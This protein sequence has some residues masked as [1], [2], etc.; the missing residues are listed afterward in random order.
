MRAAEPLDLARP[1]ADLSESLD[2]RAAAGIAK[3]KSVR[4]APSSYAAVTQTNTTAPGTRTHGKIFGTIT[5]VGGFVCSGTVV[6]SPNESTVWT[7]AHCIWDSDTDSFAT[8]LVFVPGYNNGARPFG[9][10]AARDAFVPGNWVSSDGTDSRD[11]VGTL[12]I[13]KKLR[14]KTRREKRKCN[15]RFEDRPAK[16]RRCKRKRVRG[17]VKDKVGARGIAFEQ[18][19]TNTFRAFGY[20]ASPTPRFNGERLELCVSGYT[21]SDGSNPFPP[22]DPISME[23]DMQGGASG[24]GW[25]ISGGRVNGNVSYGYPGFDDFH[26]YSPYFD[27]FTRGFYNAIKDR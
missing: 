15:R 22:P 24:G 18:P 6:N 10:W 7:A 20:P 27:N 16:R 9:N 13:Q 4:S 5:G 8:N 26:F 19:L 11:D 17:S 25:V 2:I 23:C 12:L 1:V 21:G 3:P 14:D